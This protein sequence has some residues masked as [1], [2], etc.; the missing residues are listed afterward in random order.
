MLGRFALRHHSLTAKVR[1]AI[2]VHRKG[3]VQPYILGVCGGSGSGK[4]TFCEQ[5]VQILGADKIVHLS[6]DDY[7][8]DLSLLS[9]DD[10]SRV[11]FDHPDSI[12]FSLLATHL[13]HLLAGR[14]VAIPTYDFASHTRTAVQQIISPKPIVLVEGILLFADPA[15][16]SR[17]H[18]KVFI[19][20][21]EDVRYSRRLRR[22]VRERGRTEESVQWQFQTTV[23]PMHNLFVEPHKIMADRIFSGEMPFE[24]ALL[25]LS[26]Q[27][28]QNLFLPQ[29]SL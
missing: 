19:D 28:L 11:N 14:D 7:Y 5:L 21:C 4:T 26:K 17:I 3:F 15:T 2:G 6:Q 24:P 22:D 18:L 20:A 25:D 12:E 8:K 29:R 1:E 23:R 10:R 16:A 9:P 13:E 27:L